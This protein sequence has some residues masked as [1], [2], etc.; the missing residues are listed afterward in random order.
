[1]LIHGPDSSSAYIMISIWVVF[2]VP[3]ALILLVTFRRTKLSNFSATVLHGYKDTTKSAVAQ[4]R[5]HSPI[6][7]VFWLIVKHVYARGK[8]Q[9]FPAHMSIGTSTTVNLTFG[10]MA[11]YRREETK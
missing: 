11:K 5:H 4:S 7:R 3:S 10:G 1:M 2:C 8:G 9:T 6:L